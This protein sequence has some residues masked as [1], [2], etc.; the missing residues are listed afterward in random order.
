MRS[1]A[2]NTIHFIAGLPGSGPTTP[3]R[4]ERLADASGRSD[5]RAQGCPLADPF[6]LGWP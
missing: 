1:I 2:M 6:L 4:A 5:R 3:T